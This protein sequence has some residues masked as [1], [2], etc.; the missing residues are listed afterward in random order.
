MFNQNNTALTDWGD[1]P[2]QLEGRTM[3]VTVRAPEWDSCFVTPLGADARP[4]TDKR[5]SVERSPT[6]RFSVVVET[7]VGSDTVVSRGV[8]PRLNL[9]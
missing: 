6:G 1:G 5:R 9:S 8:L 3:R 4:M 7:N 2:M